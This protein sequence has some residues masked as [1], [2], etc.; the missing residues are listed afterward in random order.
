MQH[1]VSRP[2]QRNRHSAV[3]RHLTQWSDQIGSWHQRDRVIGEP[4]QPNDGPTIC[5]HEIL[6]QIGRQEFRLLSKLYQM[7]EVDGGQGKALPTVKSRGDRPL[8]RLQIR[9]VDCNTLII[10]QKMHI[11]L[12]RALDREA[13]IYYSRLRRVEGL[14]RLARPQMRRK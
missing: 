2:H 14:S 11:E 9:D 5:D 3:R 7:V 6:R 8:E 13:V 10:E 12:V 1:G 4:R